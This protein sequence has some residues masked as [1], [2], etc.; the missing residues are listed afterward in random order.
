MQNVKQWDS[1][2]SGSTM[3]PL[4]ER[5]AADQGSD[6]PDFMPCS[7][8]IIEAGTEASGR[9]QVRERHMLASIP[10]LCG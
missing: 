9:M 6:Q 2:D 10:E 4:D 5:R 7:R 8:R 1:K 3:R